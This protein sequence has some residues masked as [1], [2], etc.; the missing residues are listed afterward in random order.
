MAEEISTL[1]TTGLLALLGTVAG[2]VV[3]GYWDVRLA[4]KDLQS[5]LLLRALEPDDADERLKSLGF[6]ITTNLISDWKIRKGVQQVI[7]SGKENIPRFSP[8]VSSPRSAREDIEHQNPDLEGKELAFVALKVRHGDIIDAI[9]PIFAEIT[10]DF[11]LGKPK[12]GMQYGGTGGEETVL[13]R[14]GCIVTG[15]NLYKGNYFGREEII[16][17]EL[18]WNRLTPQGLDP[19]AEVLS[20]KLGSGDYADID[21]PPIQLRADPGYYIYNFLASTS[22]HTSG[23]TF[24]HDFRIEQRQLPLRRFVN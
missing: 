18:I 21:K 1:L 9:T 19:S 4:D 20:E 11:R 14:S 5:K 2:G 12:V 10:P 13:Q 3:K 17:I 15:V 16:Q 24:L 6:L 23:E 7:I 8:G 22:N